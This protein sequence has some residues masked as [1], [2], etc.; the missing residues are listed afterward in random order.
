LWHLLFSVWLRV[1]SILF[2]RR[3]YLTHFAP[4]SVSKPMLS[5]VVGF[6]SFPLSA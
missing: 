6:S 3:Y 4:L 5:P 2:S 1:I